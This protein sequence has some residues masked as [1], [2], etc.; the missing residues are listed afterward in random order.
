MGTSVPPP[1]ATAKAPSDARS[2]KRRGTAVRSARGQ[3]GKDTKPSA[4]HYNLWV[5]FKA[6]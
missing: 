6:I 3:T 4:R 5:S 2:A 1:S